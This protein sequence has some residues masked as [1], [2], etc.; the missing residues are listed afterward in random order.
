MWENTMYANL[1]MTQ[2]YFFKDENET[3]N[4][5]DTIDQFSKAAGVCERFTSHDHLACI[6]PGESRSE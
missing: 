4:M 5:P 6:Q 1:Q 2:R 3:L